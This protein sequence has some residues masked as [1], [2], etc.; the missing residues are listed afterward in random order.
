MSSAADNSRIERHY[1]EDGTLKEEIEYRDGARSPNGIWR[2][3]HPNGQLAGEFFLEH[4]VYVN[5]TNRTW[6]PDGRLQHECTYVNGKITKQAMYMP[7]G[8][9]IPMPE[10][11]NRS[12]LKKAISRASNALP[13][14]ARKASD[15]EAAQDRTFIEG[16]LAS[17]TAPAAEWLR[18]GHVVAKRTLGEMG[19]ELSIEF[20][21]ALLGLGAVEVLAVEVEDIPGT[22]GQT[23]NH[24]VVRLPGPE[25][26]A[27]V[28][29]FC[30]VIA[31]DEGFDAPDDTGQDW[32]F[33]KLC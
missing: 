19:P 14:R 26:R 18:K 12:R 11:T 4:N 21:D 20:V 22:D 9:P 17:K 23:S 8:R 10:D 15:E 27:R 32:E 6:Y 2:Q 25:A 29:A 33:L 31:V 5:G 1:Y 13:K 28:L 7:T 16:L 30:G 3:W 24:L